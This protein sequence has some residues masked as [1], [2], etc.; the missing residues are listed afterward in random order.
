MEMFFLYNLQRGCFDKDKLCMAD[1]DTTFKQVCH[2]PNIER[3][4]EQ[5]A[6]GVIN[7]GGV[8]LPAD[9][10]TR[11]RLGVGLDNPL[12]AVLPVYYDKRRMN[13]LLQNM[14]KTT[15]IRIPKT[16]SCEKAFIRPNKE[17]AGCKGVM[18]LKGFCVTEEIEIQNEYVVDVINNKGF[19]IYAREVKLKNGYD[20]YVRILPEN[21]RLLEEVEKMC[22]DLNVAMPD[23]VNGIFHLQL[24]KDA[25]DEYYYIESSKRISGSAI[26]NLYFGYNPLVLYGE[27]EVEQTA[28][29]ERDKWYRYDDFVFN[30]SKVI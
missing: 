23:Y 16:F 2:C 28:L 5:D 18:P 20:K 21:D 14:P 29:F 6:I 30:L 4:S 9:E 15:R 11:Q 1:C 22:V 10:L 26:V 27:C 25:K 19:D 8:I 3:I 17:S 12:S 7:Y 24:C 13:E